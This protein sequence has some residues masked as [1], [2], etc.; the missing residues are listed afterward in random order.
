[1]AKEQIEQTCGNCKHW[2]LHYGHVMKNPR[3]GV[4]TSKE[5]RNKVK[6]RMFNTEPDFGCVDFI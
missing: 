5:V 2:E 4:C 1:M 3:V 6:Q